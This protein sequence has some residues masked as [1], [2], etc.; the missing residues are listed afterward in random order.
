MARLEAREPIVIIVFSDDAG[1][2]MIEVASDMMIGKG[3]DSDEIKSP[4]SACK[5]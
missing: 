3:S 5:C 4:I 2:S 1:G